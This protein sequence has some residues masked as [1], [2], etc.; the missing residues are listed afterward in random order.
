MAYFGQGVSHFP[1]QPGHEWTVRVGD[2]EGAL[3][4]AREL[5]SPG[6]AGAIEGYA[7]GAV[8]PDPIVSE[9]IGP[10]DVPSRL[11]GI[12]GVDAGPGPKVHVDPRL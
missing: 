7:S 6:L 2:R 8:R 4:L 1:L 5:G 12:R 9:V 3:A 10:E 11:D